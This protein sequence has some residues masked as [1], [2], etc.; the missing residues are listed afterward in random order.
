MSE[1]PVVF[2]YLAQLKLVE[3]PQVV[4]SL[5]QRAKDRGRSLE[6][7]VRQALRYWLSVSDRAGK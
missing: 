5:S 1:R 4:Q 7:E 6:E 3:D 2:G